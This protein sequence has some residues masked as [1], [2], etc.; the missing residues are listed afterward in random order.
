MLP[1]GQRPGGAVRPGV[2]HAVVE[3]VGVALLAARRVA[4]QLVAPEP[5]PAHVLDSGDDRRTHGD[6]A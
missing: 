5:E 3:E 6:R 4:V 2:L 1:D